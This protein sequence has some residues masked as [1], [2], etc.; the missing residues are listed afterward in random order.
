MKVLALSLDSL[1]LMY[2][3]HPVSIVEE[4]HAVVRST[5]ESCD[6]MKALEKMT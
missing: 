4:S 5:V 3:L 6:C 1:N 2:V